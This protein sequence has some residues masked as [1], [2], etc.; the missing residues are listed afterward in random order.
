MEANT[1]EIVTTTS[2]YDLVL[3]HYNYMAE[4]IKA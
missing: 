1:K 3:E 2:I 4:E